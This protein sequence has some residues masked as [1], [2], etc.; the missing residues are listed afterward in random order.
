MIEGKSLCIFLGNFQGGCVDISTVFKSPD[1]HNPELN[2]MN[3]ET[4]VDQ[5]LLEQEHTN[6]KA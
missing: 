6:F 4:R 1:I 2:D 3:M 5:M